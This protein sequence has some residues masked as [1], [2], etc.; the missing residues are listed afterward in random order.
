VE[1]GQRLAAEIFLDPQRGG[2]G[3]SLGLTSPLG[4]E[5]K[6]LLTTSIA[7]S[8]SHASLRRTVLIECTWRLPSLHV[9][10][11]LPAAPGLAEWL[12]G[13]CPKESA[14]R[15]VSETLTIIPAGEARDDE[16]FLLDRLQSF[17]LGVL[18]GPDDFVLVELPSM[19]STGTGRLATGLVDGLVV[20]AQA[21]VTPIAAIAQ[22][23]D[24][25]GDQVVHGVVLNQVERWIPQWIDRIL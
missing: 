2:G 24:M 22:T 13:E 11:D 4:G 12:R 19:L 18:S 5:G 23:C 6:S 7:L 15:M 17:G 25:L 16:L 9:L 20:V 1:Q 10:F 8:L 21:G 3:R 14:Q